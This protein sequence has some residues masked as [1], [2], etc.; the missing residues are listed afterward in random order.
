MSL[1]RIYTTPAARVRALKAHYTHIAIAKRIL[2]EFGPK[3]N[4]RARVVVL[5][6]QFNELRELIRADGK[7]PDKIKMPEIDHA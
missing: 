4:Y 3:G 6:N 5:E 1:D 7:D 2:G